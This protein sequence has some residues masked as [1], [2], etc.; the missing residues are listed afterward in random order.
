MLMTLDWS[1]T[2]HVVVRHREPIG[3]FAF[4]LVIVFVGAT[5]GKAT[6]TRVWLQLPGAIALFL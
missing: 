1:A 6:L 3:K 2:R 5:L 4:E